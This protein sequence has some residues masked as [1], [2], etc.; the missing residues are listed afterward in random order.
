MT[1]FMI[2]LIDTDSLERDA[3]WYF[4]LH[5]KMKLSDWFK[6]MYK[7]MTAHNPQSESDLRNYGVEHLLREIGQLYEALVE[8]KHPSISPEHE[9]QIHRLPR[10][11]AILLFEGFP[12]E[13]YDGDASHVP[14]KWVSA[15]LNSLSDIVN[16]DARICTLSVLGVRSTGK[17][18]LL[19]ALFGTQFS[20]STGRCSIYATYPSSS[21]NVRKDGC[22]LSS[23]N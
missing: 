9:H 16:S 1:T 19:N 7:E 4:M 13:I 11:A 23:N 3:V 12:I 21:L 18:T 5:L 14:Q 2:T 20:V 6:T 17:S 22:A 15:V 10:I 8:Q